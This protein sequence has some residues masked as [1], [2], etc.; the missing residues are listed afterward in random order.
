MSQA[1]IEFE[2]F[3]DAN[4]PVVPLQFGNKEIN[5]ENVGWYIKSA[6]KDKAVLEFLEKYAKKKK[7]RIIF[8]TRDRR[9]CASAG[10]QPHSLVSII[11]LQE[12]ENVAPEALRV[13]NLESS[14]LKETIKCIFSY[15][16]LNKLHPSATI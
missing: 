10:Y 1:P 8:L 14:A 16:L 11:V 7:K 4:L 3:F 2:V 9:F 6:T 5:A 15:I 12:Y 13:G